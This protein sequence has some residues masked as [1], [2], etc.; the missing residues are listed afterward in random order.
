MDIQKLKKSRVTDFSKITEGFE[1]ATNP[2]KVEYKKEVD[3]RFWKLQGDKMGNGM[4]IIRFLPRVDRS[5]KDEMPW[6]KVLS[7][8]FKGPT[9]KVYAEKSLS[10]FNET[11]PVGEY[12]F[13]LL[14]TKN[15]ADKELAKKCP[16]KE[17]YTSNILIVSDPANPQNNGKVFLFEYGKEIFKKIGEQLKP[18]LP[19][20]EPVI[21]YDLW[22]GANLKLIQKSKE[23]NELLVPSFNESYFLEKS[24]IGKTDEDKQSIVDNIHPLAEFIDRKN[25]KSYVELKSK[26]DDVM[27]F[28][29]ESSHHSE[30]RSSLPTQSAPKFEKPSYDDSVDDTAFFNGLIED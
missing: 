27:G 6:V 30:S 16:R 25:F 12:V 24:E 26:F 3:S 8:W 14:A 13:P 29:F 5:D 23:F 18:T 10:T 7:Y 4:A 28:G 21:V 1:N 17:R 22:E 11:D 2:T 9:G 15:P 20:E 19:G